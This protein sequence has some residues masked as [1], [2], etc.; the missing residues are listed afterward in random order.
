MTPHE[1]SEL[2]QERDG[3]IGSSACLG[4]RVLDAGHRYELGSLDG[5]HPQTLQFV[6]RCDAEKPWRFPGNTNSYPGATLQMVIRALL[7]RVA[8]LQQQIWC[9]ENLVITKLLQLTLWL[10]EAR[11]ARRHKRTYWHGLRYAAQSP[12]CLACGHTTCEHAS[13]PNARIC[14]DGE[15]RA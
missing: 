8:Y 11:A 4:V 2:Q 10:L 15:G 7:D 9:P 5:E 6:K 3:V 1:T 13:T 14:D 12:L